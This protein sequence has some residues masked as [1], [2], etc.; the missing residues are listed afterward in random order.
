MSARFGF[1]AFFALGL[2]AGCTSTS[3]QPR[4]SPYATPGE[5]ERNTLRAEH[6]SRQAAELIESDPERAEELLREALAEDIFYG[7]GPQQ[8]RGTPPWARP[9]LRSRHGVRVGRANS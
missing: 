1:V 9:P 6:L 3:E 4:R 5:E 7:A 8:P 2:L